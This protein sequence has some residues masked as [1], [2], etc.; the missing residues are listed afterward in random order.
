M[1][2]EA[3]ALALTAASIGFLHTLVGPDHYIPFIAMSRARRW[4]RRKTLVVTALCGVGHVLSSVVLGL[5]GIALGIALARLEG[6]E[7]TRGEIAAWLMIGFG[8]AYFAWGLKRGLRN[9]PHA[10]PHIHEAGPHDHLHAHSRDHAHVHDAAAVDGGEPAK[11]NITPW[12]LFTVFVFGPC[13]PLIP[14][15]VYPAARLGAPSVVLVTVVFAIATIGTMLAIVGLGTYGLR[16]ARFGAMERWMHAM[17][18]AVIFLCGISI[19]FL[20]L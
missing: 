5:G 7:S 19:R 11:A 13:E 20:G 18:G 14:L 10:H 16:V 6:V 2:G 4:S 17:A 1:T 8:L 15:L 9:R 3:A 12:V